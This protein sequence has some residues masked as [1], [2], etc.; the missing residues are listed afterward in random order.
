MHYQ[1]ILRVADGV[2]DRVESLVRWQHPRRGL[3]G[4]DEFIPLAEE[5]GLIVPLGELILELVIEQAKAWS[6]TLSDVQLAVNI[7]GLQLASPDFEERVMAMLAAADL[8]PKTLL[9]EVTESTVLSDQEAAHSSLARLRG[10]GIRTAIDDFGTG[11]S[12]LARIG[13]LPVT[14]VK[15][16]RQFVAGIAN[17]EKAR[18]IFAAVTQIL[19]AHGLL[20]IVEGIE[21]ADM[22]AQARAIGC[23]F[24]QGYHICRP[25][26]PELIAHQLA[27]RS[28]CDAIAESARRRA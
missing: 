20:I 5:T 25:G 7:S 17:D 26:P 1:P 28:A 18:S 3:V 12:S 16:D 21:D 6:E 22:L 19:R 24:A 14:G 15:L 10:I 11:Y 13:E 4:P 2:W 8:P 23:D 27:L 9:F